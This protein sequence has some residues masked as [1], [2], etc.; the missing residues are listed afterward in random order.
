MRICPTLFL[1]IIT[2]LFCACHENKKTKDGAARIKITNVDSTTYS[3]IKLTINESNR[4]YRITDTLA[5]KYILGEKDFKRIIDFKYPDSTIF[6]ELVIA[7]DPINFNDNWLFTI[8]QV[9]P[10]IEHTTS[11]LWILVN[12]NNGNIK[13]M[14]M[15]KDSTIQ[16]IDWVKQQNMK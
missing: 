3:E 16:L 14:D 10:K 12:A 2:G 9:Q 8:R 7:N 6:N 5:K 15:E 1:L 4:K 11:I 13:I